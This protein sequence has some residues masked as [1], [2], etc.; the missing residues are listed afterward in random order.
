MPQEETQVAQKT[1]R[2]TGSAV[3]VVAACVI[4]FLLAVYCAGC[5]F[6]HQRFWPNTRMGD[7][8]V[9]LMSRAAATEALREASDA[10]TVAVSG[11]GVEFTLTGDN[12]GLALNAEEA[13]GQALAAQSAWQWPWQAFREHD[14]GGALA[15]SF[16]AGLLRATVEGLLA[17]RN[18]AASDPQD[19]FLY[20]DGASRSFQVN[21]GS[22]GTKLDA[23][24]VVETVAEAIASGSGRAALT[25]ADL[26]QQRVTASDGALLAAREAANAL[27]SCDVELTLGGAVVAELGP[28][29]VQGWISFGGDGTA[30]VD[31]ALLAAW[32]D[33]VEALVDSAGSARSYTRPDGKAV[34]VS[35][36]TYGWVS[37]GDALER[38]V[39]DCLEGGA[40]GQAEVPLRQSAALYSPGGQDWG[41]RYL[42]VDLSEQYVR[43]YGSDGSLAWSS[44]CIT[45]LPGGY[46]TPTGV[47]CI[48]GKATGQTLV[49]LADPDTGEPEYET[50]VDYWMPFVGNL[51]GLHDASWQSDWSSS[52]YTY[53]GS[54]GCVNLPAANAASLYGLIQVGDVVVVHY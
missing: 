44:P 42:D 24:S 23:D 27:L 34:S 40:S 6:F 32:V 36:G 46:E 30:Q 14:A 38:L 25:S 9:S 17:E 47:Y 20:Y 52:A 16:D 41:A 43:L 2:R 26:V 10:L 51:I 37:D 22:A 33:S 29:T 21:P 4:V 28:D 54:H 3:V 15:A 18:G 48:T 35:G 19:A 49:G 31:G 12:A 11:Q 13:A 8:D 39:R 45:G 53:A 5:I 1:A 7:T 50:P